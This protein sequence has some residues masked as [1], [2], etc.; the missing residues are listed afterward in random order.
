MSNERHYYRT[1]AGA[2]E[3]VSAAV[4]TSPAAF[5]H[6]NDITLDG[7]RGFAFLT[8][9]WEHTYNAAT[10]LAWTAEISMDGTNYVDVTEAIIQSGTDDMEVYNP[11][12]LVTGASV[13]GTFTVPMPAALKCRVTCTAVAAD[14]SDLMTWR[15]CAHA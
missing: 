6:D 11:T 4:L 2:L 12:F 13:T 5:V 1:S 9:A 14:G 8:V 7:C 10:S 15:A 3:V